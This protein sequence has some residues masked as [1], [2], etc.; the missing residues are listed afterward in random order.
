MVP[1]GKRQIVVGVDG[2]SSAE[3]ATRWAAGESRRR[4]LPMS[5]VHAYP[6]AERIRRTGKPESG[7]PD[8][9]LFRRQAREYLDRACALVREDTPDVEVTTALVDGRP[10]EVL[11]ARAP[12]AELIVLGSRG[13]GGVSGLL[14]GSV[15][16]GLVSHAP[17]PVVIVRG[18]VA[19]A[20]DAPVVVGLDDS[21]HTDAVLAFGYDYAALH[22]APLLVVRTWDDAPVH[23]ATAMILDGDAICADE[24]LQ[25][26]E[27][28]AGWREKYPDVVVRTQVTIDRPAHAL[29]AASEGARI[30][31][32]GARGRGGMAGLL[33]G[34]TSQALIHRA[35]CPV[36]VV[37]NR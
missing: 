11:T 12:E 9:E 36:A 28:L 2:S 24:R 1:T 19:T 13:L 34:S 5:L 8:E 30:V 17:C 6:W 7:T 21:S 15:A 25:L 26:A 31:L 14:L 4:R 16:V 33:L 10:V 22:G 23:P 27:Q 20:D 29:L 3:D 37:H 18:Q 32:V 35:A